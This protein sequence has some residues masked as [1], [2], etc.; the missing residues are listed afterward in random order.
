VKGIHDTVAEK[1]LEKDSG[2]IKKHGDLELED[3]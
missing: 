3:K 2:L 1:R